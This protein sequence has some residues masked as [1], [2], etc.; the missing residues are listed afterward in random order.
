MAITCRCSE[1]SLLRQP[2]SILFDRLDLGNYVQVMLF[3]RVQG[4]MEWVSFL[5]SSEPR[6]IAQLDR[7]E[8]LSGE[9][10]RSRLQRRKSRLGVRA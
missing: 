8:G 3:A 7:G 9:V 4:S 5:R 6:G 10:A 2:F 1:R